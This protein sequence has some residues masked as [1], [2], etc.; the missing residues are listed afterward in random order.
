MLMARKL[1]FEVGLWGTIC[2]GAYIE[3]KFTE[4]L[5]HLAR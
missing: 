4:F 5:Y 1:F 3:C 2:S